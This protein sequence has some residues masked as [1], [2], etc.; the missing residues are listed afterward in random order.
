MSSCTVSRDP[1]K[2]AKPANATVADKVAS[3]QA[4][5]RPSASG[6]RHSAPRQRRGFS[7]CSQRTKAGNQHTTV[8]Q[9]KISPS[10]GKQRHL[11]QAGKRRQDQAEIADQRRHQGQNQRRQ[12]PPQQAPRIELVACRAEPIA[13]K[14]NAVILRHA[15]QAGAENQSDQ[16]NPLE[17]RARKSTARPGSRRRST[18]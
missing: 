6:W 9:A 15:D 18:A 11:A 14:I 17:Q 4:Q 3:V 7:A 1:P 13:E 12:N 16:M 10:G 5:A 8:S 2:A